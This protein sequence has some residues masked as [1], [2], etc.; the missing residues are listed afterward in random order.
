MARRIGSSVRLAVRPAAGPGH[1]A[2]L[3]ICHTGLVAEFRVLYPGLIYE[4]QR[5]IVAGPADLNSEALHHCITMALTYFLRR[6]V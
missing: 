5:A 1:V 6:R 3:F 2:L 4:G